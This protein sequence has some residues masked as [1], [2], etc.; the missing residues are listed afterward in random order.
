MTRTLR[1]LALLQAFRGELDAGRRRAEQGIAVARRQL[2][3]DPDNASAQRQLATLLGAAAQIDDF[4]GGE[5]DAAFKAAIDESI[6]LLERLY[7]NDPVEV[8]TGANLASMYGLRS[9]H[10][11]RGAT[12][13]KDALAMLADEERSIAVLLA[14]LE[15]NPDNTILKANLAV[16]YD[17]RG[18][19]LQLLDR[20]QEAVA[21]H[22]Q[23]VGV[24]EPMVAKDP[25]NVML[26]VDLG[27]F[28]GELSDALLLVGQ[29]QAAVEAARTALDT[30]AK[31]P[32]DARNNLVSLRDYG[33]AH[34]YMAN[35]LKA[36][37][38]APR[39]SAASIKADKAEACRNLRKSSELFKAHEAKFG[40]G[41]ASMPNVADELRG[42]S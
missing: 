2:K 31:V 9:Q 5:R 21:S 12:P 32:E 20:K 14:L 16:V 23:A 17:H 38:E 41:G 39:Q 15:K 29:W 28:N 8:S 36:R 30:F 25:D 6:V 3:T 13:E 40:A 4:A 27:T 10:L 18:Y 34:Y 19:A 37:A 35:A 42:C 33:M 1:V 7:A 11:S 24:L 26:R 22:R